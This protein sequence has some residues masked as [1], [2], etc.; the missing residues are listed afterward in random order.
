MDTL[1]AAVEGAVAPPGSVVKVPRDLEAICLK[2]LQKDPA[3]RYASGQEL[4]DDLR[5]FLEG[6]AVAAGPTGFWRRMFFRGK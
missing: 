4:A 6:R 1:Y 5:R 3:K 2:C